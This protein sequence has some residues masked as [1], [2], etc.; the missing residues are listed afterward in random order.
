MITILFYR[1]FQE[2]KRY[3]TII[4]LDGK[5]LFVALKKLVT[6]SKEII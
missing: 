2:K 4:K 6:R 1:Y 5:I 3:Q